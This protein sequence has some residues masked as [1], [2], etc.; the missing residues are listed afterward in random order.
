MRNFNTVLSVSMCCLLSACCTTP[1]NDPIKAAWGLVYIPTC[2]QTVNYTGNKLMVK[3]IEIPLGGKVGKIGEISYD[4]LVLVQAA[5]ITQILDQHQRAACQLL[6]TLASISK[7]KF[8]NA[9]Q[10]MLTDQ[11]ILDQLAVISLDPSALKNWV[12]NY[13]PRASVITK[14]TSDT[15]PSVASALA[16]SI[17]AAPIITA[18][19]ELKPDNKPATPSPAMVADAVVADLSSIP[20]EAV[21]NAAEV[22]KDVVFLDKGLSTTEAEKIN[23]VTP[24]TDLTKN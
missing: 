10:Q 6:P 12:E 23:T 17:A 19:K 15:N 1:V 8:E 13:A 21:P 18:T 24:L 4:S 11:S 14:K 16:P 3:G 22:N 9:L 20:Q 2:I 7:D 5:F